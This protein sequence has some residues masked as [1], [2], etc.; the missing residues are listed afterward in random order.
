MQIGN[1]AP[2]HIFPQG[3]GEAGIV[4]HDHGNARS[5]IVQTQ[6]AKVLAVPENLARAGV[7]EAAQQ[8]GQGG[9]A[10]A[11]FSD[12]GHHFS[13]LNGEVNVLQGGM[14]ATGVNKRHISNLNA[15]LF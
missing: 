15:L 9:L 1:A 5:Q 3:S 7:V 11:V 10:R 6:G 2:A 12:Q 14:V 8:L 13:R 4:L